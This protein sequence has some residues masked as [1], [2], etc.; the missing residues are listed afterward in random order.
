LARLRQ[1]LT[2]AAAL[3]FL[4]LAVAAGFLGLAAHTQALRA[5]VAAQEAQQQ[6]EVAEDARGRAENQRQ[7]AE[8]A[9]AQ[10]DAQRRQ[11]DTARTQAD[12]Q[13]R[14]AEMRLAAADELLDGDGKTE[15]LRQCL[16]ATERAQSQPPPPASREFFLGRWHVDQGGGTTDVDW[17]ADGT[18]ATR[19]VF[20]GGTHAVDLT[21]NVCT[22]QFEKRSDNEFVINYRST[23]LGDNY[24]RRLLFRIINPSRIHNIDLNY[25]AY[26][27][28]CPRH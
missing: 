1:R 12:I 13:R 27:I 8:T 9:R 17:N 5:Q 20:E 18:C 22:W 4:A 6:R 15:Q 16:A 3:V 10:A 14:A 28:V 21:A 26:R 24:P 25:D 19:N 11:A 23:K 2:A 7:Q